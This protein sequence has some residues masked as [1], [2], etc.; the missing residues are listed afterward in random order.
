MPVRGVDRLTTG[1]AG[2][3]DVDLDLIVRDLDRVRR[4]D[5]R[6]DLD[7]GERGL[8]ATLVVEGRDA[9][10]AMGACLD[11]KGAVGVG[12]LDLEGGR[13]Q[14]GLLGV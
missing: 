3:E 10:E 14:A 7:R 2:A 5:E 12:D 1:A 8:P 6:N 13:L 11:R 4:L 9:H